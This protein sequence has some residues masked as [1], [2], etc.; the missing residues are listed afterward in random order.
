MQSTNFRNGDFYFT[1]IDQYTC[2]LGRLN[3]QYANAPVAGSK[4]PKSL[5]KIPSYVSNGTNTFRVTGV[6]DRSFR[7]CLNIKSVIIPNTIMKK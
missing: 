1:Y 2:Y 6:T 4:Y 7:D 5:L 3:D